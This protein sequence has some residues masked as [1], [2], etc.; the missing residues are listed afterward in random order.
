MPITLFETV[1]PNPTELLA[2][3]MRCDFGPSSHTRVDAGG[4]RTLVEDVGPHY[5]TIALGGTNPA[6]RPVRTANQRII[7]AI[8]ER[9]FG[10]SVR[11]VDWM[12]RRNLPGSFLPIH[13]G[14]SIP[15]RDP[16]TGGTVWVR[17]QPYTVT[18]VLWLGEWQGGEIEFPQHALTLKPKP[19]TLAVFPADEHH[20]HRVHP[21]REGC[22]IAWV[23]RYLVET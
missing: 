22:R 20:L 17:T 14:N 21:V 23:G 15:H 7:T 13:A 5:A 16:A 6:F 18:S 19:N 1:L 9:L 2:E 3:I 10:P 12:V 8:V 4:N 11:L